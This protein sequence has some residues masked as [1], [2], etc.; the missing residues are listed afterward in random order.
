MG[1]SP[2]VSDGL[3]VLDPRQGRYGSGVGM[4][5]SDFFRRDSA[6]ELESNLLR[7][8][9]GEF[10]EHYNREPFLV[11]HRL[12]DHPMFEL[13][14]LLELAKRSETV[15]N[16]LHWS[17]RIPVATNFDQAYQNHGT[18]IPL[19]ETIE[20]IHEAGSFVVINYPESDALYAPLV[21]SLYREIRRFSDPLDPDFTEVMAYV[22]IS[23]PGSV[24]PYHMDREMNFLLQISGEKDVH[25]WDPRDRSIMTEEQIEALMALPQLPRPG[26]KEEFQAKAKVVHL[27]PGLGVHHPFIAPHW[28]RN[29][30][31]VSVS[32]AL[33]YRT[34]GSQR[35]TRAYQ[36]NHAL[37]RLKLRPRP[38]GQWRLGDAIKGE[39]YGVAR[40]VGPL[41]KSVFRRATK[42]VTS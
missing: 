5:A 23:S 17:G 41:L 20:R 9:S 10:R 25:L 11:R 7:I 19:D 18:G 39:L 27:T 35:L 13:P 24:T 4:L 36:T 38:V 15:G 33:T 12:A 6:G 32:L 1:R 34:R 40:P 14:K 2:V 28:V 26:Y 29:G 30:P 22:F 3:A 16:A 42:F 31:E 21:R 37:R 8:D